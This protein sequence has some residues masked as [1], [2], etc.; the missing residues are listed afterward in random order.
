MGSR[1]EE[2]I[3]FLCWRISFYDDGPLKLRFLLGLGTGRVFR[4]LGIS[5]TGI[6]G[7][8]ISGLGFRVL[9]SNG[10]PISGIW[11]PEIYT[12]FFFFVILIHIKYTFF[13]YQSSTKTRVNP[14]GLN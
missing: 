9:D 11:V 5:G 8:G 1:C 14:L 12:S 7:S 6:S 4:V 3:H 13:S 2:R 10:Y